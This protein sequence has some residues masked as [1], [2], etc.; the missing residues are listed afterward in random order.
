MEYKKEDREGSGYLWRENSSDS[1]VIEK[2]T[3]TLNGRVRY[4]GIIKSKNNDGQEKLEFFECIG[5][6]HINDAS[7]KMSEKTPDKGGKVT[8]DNE[9]HKL[10]CWDKESSEGIPFT[11]IG[12]KKFDENYTA[13]NVKKEN[14]PF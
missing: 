5:L 11:S 1:T 4:G 6:L 13:P 8:I 7:S 10:G 3:F 2:G 9:I 12:F 14:A